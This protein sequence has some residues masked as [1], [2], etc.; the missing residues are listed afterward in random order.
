M[1]HRTR[2][3]AL[4]LCAVLMLSSVPALAQE[5]ALQ[6]APMLAQQVAEGKLPGLE[7]RL[8]AKEDIMIEPVV[9]GIG[10]YGGSLNITVGDSGRWTWGPY[11]EQ[12][13]FRFKQ[14]GSGE[15]EPN[16]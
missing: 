10:Q 12:S 1:K 7:E 8:P 4:A 5:T 9:E 16:I 14:D 11:V 3:I 15:V 6:E 2:W 13:M